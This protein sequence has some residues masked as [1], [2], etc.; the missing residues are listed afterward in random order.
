MVIELAC[1]FEGAKSAHELFAHGRRFRP[2][3]GSD[4]AGDGD[5]PERD[6][7]RRFA[8]REMG[9]KCQPRFSFL[10]S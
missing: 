9:V 5:T 2:D 7:I 3:N 10:I 6:S 4:T 8:D 1:L